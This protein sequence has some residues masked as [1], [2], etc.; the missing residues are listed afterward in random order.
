MAFKYS[1]VFVNN[2]SGTLSLAVPGDPQN[3]AEL[4]ELLDAEAYDNVRNFLSG[5][6]GTIAVSNMIHWNSMEDLELN[7]PTPLEQLWI[8]NLTVVPKD[9]ECAGTWTVNGEEIFPAESAD[10]TVE[11]ENFVTEKAKTEELEVEE[12]EVEDLSAA[13]PVPEE[14][15]F[16]KPEETGPEPPET[17][18]ILPAAEQPAAPVA[19][20][21][22]MEEPKTKEIKTV[23]IK[24]K[25]TKTEELRK[26]LKGLAIGIVALIVVRLLLKKRK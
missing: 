22:P 18:A 25:E 2:G 11:R 19:E 14:E 5:A 20:E 26:I 16:V 21:P 13:E 10:H 24:T 1:L 8:R 3:R 23:E 12:P 15:I 6:P 9:D 7:E 4:Q 17:E